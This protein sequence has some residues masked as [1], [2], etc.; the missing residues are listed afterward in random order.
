MKKIWG[1]TLIEL[2][3]VLI[4][5]GILAVTILPRFANKSDF[6]QAGF[7]DQVRASLQYARKIA[8]ASRR[9]VCVTV[10][11]SSVSLQVDPRL[12]ENAGSP[13]C[14]VTPVSL[15]MPG[16]STAT[17][18]APS[19]VALGTATFTFDPLGQAS[20]ATSISITGGS[21]IQVEQAGYVH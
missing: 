5:V 20:A 3:V 13:Y 6:E 11:A 16:S 4:I 2:V 9:Y 19:S 7:R 21:P 10:G 8:V 17:L 18:T 1:F 15:L 14:S 12:P